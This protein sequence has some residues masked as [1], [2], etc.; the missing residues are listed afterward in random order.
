MTQIDDTRT[1][2]E[3]QSKSYTKFKL[4]ISKHARGNWG[5]VC[6]FCILSSK[7]GITPTKIDANWRQSYLICCTVTVN[8]EIFAW[9]NF[10][11]FV[12]FAKIT[13]TRKLNS[14]T[15]MKEIGKVSWKIPPREMPCQYFRE[16]FP[17]RK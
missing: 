17:Q 6:N 7:R 15:F 11:A 9:G 1:W 12:F 16:I 2:S 4:N 13:P 8:V 3:V 5:K 14:H 10:R